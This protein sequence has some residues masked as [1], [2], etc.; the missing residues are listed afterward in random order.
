MAKSK[1]QL[2]ARIDNLLVEINAQYADL[3]NSDQLE[4]IDIALLTSN[5]DYVSTQLKA[6]HYFQTSN[7]NNQNPSKEKP[8]FTP[9][10]SLEKEADEQET[11][12]EIE[13][14]QPVAMMYEVPKVEIFSAYVEPIEEPVKE[15][16]PEPVVRPEAIDV[17]N[18]YIQ[19]PVAEAI[20]KTVVEE[21]T[22]IIEEVKESVF[23]QE[24]K[25]S[26]VEEVPSRPLSIN[27]LIQQQKKAGVNVT[28]QFQTSTSQEKVT[29]LKIAISLNDKLLFIKDLFN[30]YSLAYSEALELLNRF[31]NYAEA[32][33]FLQT[34][35]ALKNGWT[36]KPQTVDKF[37][38]LLRKKFH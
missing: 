23:I 17:K 28:Q 19:E 22:V 33:A 12:D 10:I 14:V 36:E 18:E 31:D 1:D 32:D 16:V 4:G 3:K 34:N 5:I 9:S 24:T 2:L 13:A 7:S 26:H 37:Y 20:S 38:T 15:S 30:G 6:L 25:S 21:K 8:F 11:Y 35:Y 29:D 27:E